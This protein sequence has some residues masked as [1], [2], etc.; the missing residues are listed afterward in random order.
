MDEMLCEVL[1]S[2]QFFEK[3]AVASGGDGQDGFKHLGKVAWHPEVMYRKDPSVAHEYRS[4]WS[5]SEPAGNG[6]G[7]QAT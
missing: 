6:R 2:T 4:C 1:F 5:F 7:I 3:E